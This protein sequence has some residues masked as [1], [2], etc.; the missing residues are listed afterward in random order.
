[1]I[2]SIFVYPWIWILPVVMGLLLI[3]A[4]I[5]ILLEIF[6]N[7]SYGEWGI[8]AAFLIAGL[9]GTAGGYFGGMLP[10]Y[11]LSYHQMYRV[12]G[13]VTNI[14]R[15]FNDGSGIV[16][17]SY[18]FEIEGIDLKLSTGDQRF[19]G[20]EVG[21]EVQLKCEKQ[22]AYFTTPWYDCDFGG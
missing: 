18:V 7:N 20:I 15:P 9:I 5:C 17:S 19:R 13:E 11:D 10:P 8:G 4:V 6:G 22:F 3:G 1:M 2:E 14:E 12:T 16:G 21:D